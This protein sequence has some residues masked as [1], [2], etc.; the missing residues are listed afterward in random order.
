M[1]KLNL[2]KYRAERAARDPEFAHEDAVTGIIG[3]LIKA[4]ML[5]GLTQRD[6]AARL[7][8]PQARIAEFESLDGRRVSL[9]LTVRYAT[10]LGCRLE[11]LTQSARSQPQVAVESRRPYTTKKLDEALKS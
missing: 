5:A 6:L 11:L 1:K 10:A 2:E 4:R 8:I 9:D 3:S 7:G